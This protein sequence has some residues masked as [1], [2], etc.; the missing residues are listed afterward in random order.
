[1]GK[2][3][4]LSD[5]TKNKIS[6]GEVVERP[7]SVVKE[8]L[9][10][11][12][13]ADATNIQIEI[14]DGGKKLINVTDQNISLKLINDE[15]I[16]FSSP[17]NL[18]IKGRLT[19]VFGKE[20]VKNLIPVEFIKGNLKIYGYVSKFELNRASKNYQIFFVNGRIVKNKILNQ[21]IDEAYHTLIPKDR[22]PVVVLFIDISPK[23][24]DVN[25]HPTKREIKFEN[26]KSLKDFVK[27][28]VMQSLSKVKTPHL[29]KE[30]IDLK[31]YEKKEDS[32]VENKIFLKAQDLI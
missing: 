29:L 5:E 24:I 4:V 13:D 20:I 23:I 10:N 17:S 11:S 12:V 2:I 21:A 7:V 19:K 16:T 27:E 18:D 8:L 32:F 28:S 22:Y 3:F 9:E 30:K 6:A 31:F 25:V 15:K 26:P 1:M 14:H